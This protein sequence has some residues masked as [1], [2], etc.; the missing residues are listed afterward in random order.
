[1]ELSVLVVD[2]DEGLG[3]KHVMGVDGLT[4]VLNRT[5]ERKNHATR[6]RNRIL[7]GA[8]D[9]MTTCLLIS[10][11]STSSKGRR[12]WGRIGCNI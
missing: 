8:C 3:L 7:L 10:G 12:Y 4:G 11:N 2:V 9:Q 6:S 5:E 1:M